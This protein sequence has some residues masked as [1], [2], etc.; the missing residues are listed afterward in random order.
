VTPSRSEPYQ[1]VA[2]QAARRHGRPLVRPSSLSHGA[3]GVFGTK[4]TIVKL[5]APHVMGIERDVLALLGTGGVPVP[6][7]LGH[8]VLQVGGVPFGYLVMERLPGV[9]VGG[10]WSVLD[11]P[12]WMHIARSLGSIL[13]QVHAAPIPPAVARRGRKK[14]TGEPANGT[15]GLPEPATGCRSVGVEEPGDAAPPRLAAQV[16]RFLERHP[17]AGDKERKRLLHGDIHDGNVLVARRTSGRQG[18]GG[19]LAGIG[20][21]DFERAHPGDPAADLVAAHLRVL[22]GSRR[23]YKVVLEGYGF[24]EPPDPNRLLVECILHPCGLFDALFR[25][26]PDLR[27]QADLEAVGKAMWDLDHD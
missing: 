25:V 5:C 13:R 3:T 14:P 6:R 1:D 11:W 10:A 21:V 23:L 9:N 17:P 19:G 26:R 24:V 4:D 22:G 8:G 12:D 20:L 7:V 27:E 16:P 15:A 18:E 2:E